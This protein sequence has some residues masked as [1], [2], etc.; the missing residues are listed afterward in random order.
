MSRVLTFLVLCAAF[1]GACST[2]GDAGFDTTSPP[3]PS[4]TGVTPSPPNLAAARVGLKQIAVLEQPLA[5]AVRPGD[6]ALYVAEKPGRVVALRGTAEPEV[7]LDISDEVS[8]GGEQGLLGL[9]FSPDGDFLYVDYTDTTG[10]THIS[11]F[12]VHH[13]EIDASTERLVLFVNQPFSNHNGG[14]LVFGPD[15]DLYIGLG[16][17]GSAGDPMDN[18]QSLQTLLGKILRISPRPAEGDPYTI[19]DGNPFADGAAREIWDYGLRN[20]WRFSFDRL[21]GD[22]WIG[23]VGQNAWEEV[24]FA[25]AGSTSGLN[26]G[27]NLFEGTHPFEPGAAAQTVP[28]VYEYPHNGSTCVVTGGYVYR[29]QEIP[30]LEGAYVFGDFCLG[31][32]EALRQLDGQDPQVVDLGPVVENLASFGEDANGE[33]YAL[34]LSGPVYRLV[35]VTS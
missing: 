34:S 35:A 7:V 24:D 17:G 12:E 16:D 20:P 4:N 27:W 2:G 14:Q 11:E 21:T 25:A 8:L 26:F 3:S 23:D 9:A 28:P 19:P 13:G 1:A 15:G 32:L 33:L 31:R 10:D 18:G 30:A 5:M 22:L 6:P 29:G